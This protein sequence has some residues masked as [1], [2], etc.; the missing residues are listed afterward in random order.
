MKNILK[1][2]TIAG[3]L[4][5]FLPFFQMCSDK[6]NLKV[7]EKTTMTTQKD[8]EKD[9]KPVTGKKTDNS[10]LNGYQMGVF[11]FQTE[12]TFAN[13]IKNIF[14]DLT[15][16][17]Y[18]FFFLIVIN[19]YLTALFAFLNKI[20]NVRILSIM[21]IVLLIS[22][23]IILSFSWLEEI[24]QIKF[25]SYLYLLNLMAII[26]FT[27]KLNKTQNNNTTYEQN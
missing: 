17:A 26:Y 18:I 21:N 12:K 5:L 1:Y 19:T 8:T 27:F 9:V 20:R 7:A 10:V 3:I 6:H 25:G 16:F 2:L 13:T 15:S 11:I 22:S 14:N 24:S 4:I 23:Y